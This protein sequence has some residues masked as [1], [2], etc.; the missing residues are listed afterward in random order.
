M[1]GAP[2]RR[3]C[4]CVDGH[5]HGHGTRQ[6]K[7]WIHDQEMD[8]EADEGASAREVEEAGMVQRDARRRGEERRGEHQEGWQCPAQLIR[9]VR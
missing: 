7:T 4:T 3:R 9:S 2:Q 6:D 1:S 5:G 8:D